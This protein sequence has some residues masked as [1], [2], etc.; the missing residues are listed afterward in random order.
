MLTRIVA[1]AAA[2][3][4]GPAVAS[5]ATHSLHFVLEGPHTL[6]QQ[7]EVCKRWLGINKGYLKKATGGKITNL[8]LGRKICLHLPDQ[9]TLERQLLLSRGIGR[10]LLGVLLLLLL[11]RQGLS[12]ATDFALQILYDSKTKLDD[13]DN[14]SARELHV[15]VSYSGSP[16]IPRRGL[17]HSARPRVAASG[18][19]N[20]TANANSP[21]RRSS[22]IPAPL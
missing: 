15:P 18:S 12:E 3:R 4:P 5:C 11:C 1:T 22:T 6:Q 8:I 2:Y 13:H 7:Q 10:C 20:R 9:S 17:F 14:I 19:R 16:Q 21:P